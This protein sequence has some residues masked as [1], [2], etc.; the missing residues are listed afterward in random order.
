MDPGMRDGA[1]RS[2]E[3]RLSIL[4]AARTCREWPV[5][6]AIWLSG[7]IRTPTLGSS[8]SACGI[9]A[10]AARWKLGLAR[11][12]GNVRDK[13]L[14]WVVFSSVAIQVNSEID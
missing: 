7:E 1:D 6:T 8:V 11:L 3:G 2:G 14:Q 5:A 12:S 13:F 10:A 4:N 9:S